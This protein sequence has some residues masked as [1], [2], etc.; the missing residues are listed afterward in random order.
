VAKAGVL[1][2]VDGTLVDSNYHHAIAWSRALRDHG[3]NARL[4]VIHRLIGMGSAQLLE[5]LIGHSDDAIAKSWRE[6]FDALVPEVYPFDG[7]AELL[8]ALHARG[9]LVVLATSSPKDLLD[10]FRS[11]IDAD[12]A[13]DVVVTAGDVERAKPEPDVFEVSLA[14]AELPRERAV[15][16]GDSTWDVQAA[17]RT[18][19]RCIG[20][21][22]GGFCR[23]E[24]EDDGVLAVYRDPTDL[25]EH[26]DDSPIALLA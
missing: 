1:V 6:Y 4:A 8:R 26:L 17:A 15:V 19:L 16:I 14:K 11:R 18:Q 12:D 9:L 23:S 13:V 21:E 2:D 7:A 10:R 20:V 5:T 25:L 22:T 3:C 24:L